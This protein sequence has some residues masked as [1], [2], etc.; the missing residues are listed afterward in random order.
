MNAENNRGTRRLVGQ[1]GLYIFNYG[2]LPRRTVS[3]YLAGYVDGASESMEPEVSGIVATGSHLD[4]DDRVA[5]DHTGSRSLYAQ[6]D[7][8]TTQEFTT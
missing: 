2:K 8:H 6:R 1:F 3:I 4:S 7:R 5:P